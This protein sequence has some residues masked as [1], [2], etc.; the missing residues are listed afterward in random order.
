M[1]S[2]LVL[3]CAVSLVAAILATFGWRHLALQT[4]TLAV[5]N[6][7]S[8]HAHTVPTPTGGGLGFLIGL[9]AGVLAL[10][11]LGE[12]MA[13]VAT[14]VLGLAIL[15]GVLGGLDDWIDIRWSVRLSAQIVLG[16]VAIYYLGTIAAI[17]LPGMTLQLAWFG[18]VLSLVFI[19]YMINIYNFMDGID[20]IAASQAIFV[21]ALFSLLSPGAEGSS[22]ALLVSGAVAGFLGLNLPPARIFMGDVGSYFLGGLIAL[23]V[24]QTAHNETV[25]V[26]FWAV[27]MAL[28]VTDATTTLLSRL[29]QGQNIFTA[30]N[31]H[32]YQ[33][34]AR[35][36]GVR[37]T[38]TGVWAI[39][40]A[41]LLPLA[42]L[43]I[44]HPGSGFW[45][46]LLGYA[47]LIVLAVYIGAGR[48]KTLSVHGDPQ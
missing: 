29:L 40:L 6:Q 48:R 41:W 37:K 9:L 33:H 4:N 27:A 13:P 20:G 43:T 36:I 30:H 34:V 39:N 44:N 7:R 16:L 17:P 28:F 12:P 46:A 10:W 19:V 15:A 2:I 21:L 23:L 45:F 18:G 24:I 11:V 47:P 3:S 22:L 35:Q 25:T 1:M 26:W 14:H 31:T 5:P 42:W 38:L 8:A 32:A